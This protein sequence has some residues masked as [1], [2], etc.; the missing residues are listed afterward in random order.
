[1]TRLASLAAL[2]ALGTACVVIDRDNGVDPDPWVPPPNSAPVVYDAVAYCTYDGYNRDD[3]WVFEATVDDPDGVFDVVSVF[4]DVYD[5]R[6]GVLV[7][8]FELFP[9]DDPYLWFSDWLASTTVVDCFYPFYSVD[10]VAYDAYD[11]AGA[12]TILADTY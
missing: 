4:A 3:I 1:M 9:T 10:V 5:D 2:L 11:A 7:Q 12:I 8:S 6:S